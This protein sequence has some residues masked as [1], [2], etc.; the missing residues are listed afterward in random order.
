MSGQIIMIAVLLGGMY[1]LM[2]RPQSKRAKEHSNLLSGL[3]K[4]DEVVTTGGLVGKI[5]KI[6]DQFLILIIA[7]GVEVTV[8]KQAVSFVL[9]KG[10]LKSI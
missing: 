1:F 8:Q 5:N 4:G 3:V 10:T 7:E 6:V 9:P 2:I